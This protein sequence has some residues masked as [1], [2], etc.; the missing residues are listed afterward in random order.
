MTS[1]TLE[2]FVWGLF[3]WLAILTYR[4]YKVLNDIMAIYIHLKHL[5]EN[6]QTNRIHIIKEK[7]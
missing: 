4:Y 7:L 5:L 6:K 1:T 2:F 3:F